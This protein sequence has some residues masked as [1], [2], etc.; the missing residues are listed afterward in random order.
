MKIW[1]LVTIDIN[2]PRDFYGIRDIHKYAGKKICVF[3]RTLGQYDYTGNLFN[4]DR[5]YN[6]SWCP[7]C[8]SE[9][10]EL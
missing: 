3:K 9:V 6:Y 8:F 5:P 2:I 1:Y 7:E 10:H 4:N